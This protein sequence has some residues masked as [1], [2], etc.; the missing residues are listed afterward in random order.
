MAFENVNVTNLRYALNSCKNSL[1][2]GKIQSLSSTIS[3]SSWS[4]NAKTN[5]T[6]ALN[7]LVNIR[8][9]SLENQIN[10]YL[11]LLSKIESYKNLQNQN[12]ALSGE[13]ND[14]SK[15]LYVKKKVT[16]TV[17]RSNGEKVKKTTT[18]TVLDK[19]VQARMNT[20]NNQINENNSYMARLEREVSNAI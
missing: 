4:A 5:L 20:I 2:Y 6:Q 14:I 9:K 8:Y 16:K 17:T 1:N 13:Y 18:K 7:Q 12:S 3:S 19:S 15:R 10:T 11:N